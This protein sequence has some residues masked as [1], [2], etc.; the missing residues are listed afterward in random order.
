MHYFHV[1]FC[2]VVKNKQDESDSKNHRCSA[3]NIKVVKRRAS[4]TKYFF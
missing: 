2:I 1:F 3:K 4:C